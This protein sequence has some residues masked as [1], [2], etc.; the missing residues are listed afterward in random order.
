MPVTI[1]PYLYIEVVHRPFLAKF[2]GYRLACLK[3]LKNI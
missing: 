2:E 1:S 3:H